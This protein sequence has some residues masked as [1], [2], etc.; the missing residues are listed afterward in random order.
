M[1]SAKLTVVI[2]DLNENMP[3]DERFLELKKMSESFQVLL[4]RALFEDEGEPLVAEE[5]IYLFKL[6]DANNANSI[7][8]G[9]MCKAL[10]DKS[11][12]TVQDY[13]ER[14]KNTRLSILMEAKTDKQLQK[15]MSGKLDSNDDG[16]IDIH[17]WGT[18]IAQIIEDDIHFLVRKGKSGANLIHHHITK[19]IIKNDPF[20][21]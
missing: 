6:L 3:L 13:L 7:S 2:R 18:F 9:D 21:I 20:L 17:E 10:Q 12:L 4:L 15:C 1:E 11:N 8:Y 14:H 19:S 5:G 16:M